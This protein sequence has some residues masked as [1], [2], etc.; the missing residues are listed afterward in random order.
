M[1]SAQGAVKQQEEVNHLSEADEKLLRVK[2][3]EV[4]DDKD[5]YLARTARGKLR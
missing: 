3:N 2:F 4:D 1:S 5:G